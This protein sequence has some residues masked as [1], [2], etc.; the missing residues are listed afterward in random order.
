MRLRRFSIAATCILSAACTSRSENDDSYGAKR[1]PPPLEQNEVPRLDDF[2]DSVKPG[3]RPTRIVSLNPSTTE[4][5]FAL[6][7]GGRL[8]GRTKYDLWPDSARLIPA[9]GDAIRP[10]VEAVLGKKPDLVVLY[11]SEDN[12]AAAERFRAAGV[13]TVSLKIDSIAE[14]RR[15]VLML[16]AIVGAPERARLV[17]DSV[18]RTLTRVRAATAGLRRPTVFW[19]VWDAPLITI[20][21]GSFMNELVEIAGG[22]NVYSDLAAPSPAVSLEDV[23]KRNPEFILAGPTGAAQLA[24]DPRWRIVEASRAGRVL[25]VDTTLV[26]R[27]SV[28]LG[29]A[30]LSLAR[31]LHPEVTR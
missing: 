2:G 1:S 21:A 23:S 22:R 8:I 5:I 30:A 24:A 4:I 31:L 26:A 14:F 18:D 13:S 7:A 27:P 20:G 29:E 11:A 25:T 17:V 6:G 3:F 9:L 15:S 28:R 10:N 12:R 16:G 19:H